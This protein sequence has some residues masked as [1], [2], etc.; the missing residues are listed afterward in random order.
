MPPSW[1]TPSPTTDRLA[2]VRER[3]SPGLFP[4]KVRQVRYNEKERKNGP[5]HFVK[6][7]VGKKQNLPHRRSLQIDGTYTVA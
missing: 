6:D 3:G 7:L 2:P 1:R 5:Q 4:G